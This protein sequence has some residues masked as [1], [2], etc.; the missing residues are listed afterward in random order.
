[1]D[2]ILV[3]KSCFFIWPILFEFIT[4]KLSVSVIFCAFELGNSEYKFYS[5]TYTV[6]YITWSP[7]ISKSHGAVLHSYI[8]S[9]DEQSHLRNGQ[10]LNYSIKDIIIY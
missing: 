9:F 1:M 7:V 6:Y 4:D 3:L 5:I 2:F 8:I 10:R